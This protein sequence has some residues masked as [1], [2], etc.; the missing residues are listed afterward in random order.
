MCGGCR[1]DEEVNWR[2]EAGALYGVD[3][4]AVRLKVGA[5]QPLTD[6]CRLVVSAVATGGFA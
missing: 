5:P 2:L 3:L 6:V 4:S 1:E